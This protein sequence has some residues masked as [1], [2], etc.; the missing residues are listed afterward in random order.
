MIAVNAIR[1]IKMSSLANKSSPSFAL[2]VARFPKR[3]S[4]KACWVIH[5]IDFFVDDVVVENRKKKQEERNRVRTLS[6]DRKL[7]KRDQEKRDF[8]PY[9]EV[10]NVNN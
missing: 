1:K 5:Y 10:N 2:S 7:D 6:Y 3:Q 9:A 4:T 8:D